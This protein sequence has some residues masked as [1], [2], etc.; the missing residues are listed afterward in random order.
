MTIF[1]ALFE[2]SLKSVIEPDSRR[3]HHLGK[4]EG[5]YSTLGRSAHSVEPALWNNGLW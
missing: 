4:E 3:N 1:A 2:K 5:F